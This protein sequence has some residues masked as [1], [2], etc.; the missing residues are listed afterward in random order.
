MVSKAPKAS[1]TNAYGESA[2]VERLVRV[3]ERIIILS[4]KLEE[5]THQD[6]SNFQEMRIT[7]LGL[8]KKVDQILLEDARKRGQEE[9][10]QKISKFEG[11]K[12]GAIVGGFIAGLV[13]V[14]KSLLGQ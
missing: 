3:E 10:S 1:R 9:E 4:S 5:H 7:L 2:I 13:W 14:V 12:W 11:G 8:D 6:E